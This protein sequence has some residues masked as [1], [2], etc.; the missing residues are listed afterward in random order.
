MTTTLSQ[1]DK[2][3]VE[4]AVDPQLKWLGFALIGLFA[5]F[6]LRAPYYIADTW[7]HEH[8]HFALFVPLGCAL[9]LWQ[10]PPR[11]QGVEPGPAWVSLTLFGLAAIFC[12][13]AFLVRTVTTWIAGFCLAMLALIHAWG[14]L[15]LVKQIWPAWVF[16]LLMV[17]PPQV[18]FSD[19]PV[20][21]QLL[22]S[23][24]SSVSLDRLLD[25]P[26]YLDGNIIRLDDRSLFVA[27]ACSGINSLFATF[28]VLAY[29]VLFYRR[30]AAHAVGLFMLGF[31]AVLG[32]NIFRVTS[33][34]AIY[35][36]APDWGSWLTYGMPHTIFGLVCFALLVGLVVSCDAFLSLFLRKRH[37]QPR[38][39]TEEENA[40]SKPSRS[41]PAW[42]TPAAAQPW[43]W[44]FVAVTFW[45]LTVMQVA[46]AATR[47]RKP[48]VAD[49]LPNQVQDLLP[50]QWRGY[51]MEDYEEFERGSEFI[52]ANYSSSWV[53]RN[54]E[55][56]MI[57]YL[58]RPY[59]D[60]HDLAAC[61]RAAGWSVQ[62]I[63]SAN[64]ALENSPQQDL[65]CTTFVVEKGDAPLQIF[66][67]AMIDYR[68][69]KTLAPGKR[70]PYSH[71]NARVEVLK[72]FGK[73]SE[74]P[75]EAMAI[76]VLFETSRSHINSDR[77]AAR[78][79]VRILAE[80]LI[81][82]LQGMH[83]N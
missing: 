49:P 12:F 75:R 24:F 14:G 35:W 50:V 22:V 29:A 79:S 67:Y 54:P 34:T 19:L 63:R 64:L 15:R 56:K 58:H 20:R 28:A 39:L 23:H 57:V 41:S 60:W 82:K 47:F 33:L 62:A 46:A 81:G 77:Q 6:A 61:Y 51:W 70:S 21:L 1:T 68:N 9:L 71:L 76:A 3:I 43:L 72:D 36:Y 4:A 45:G 74:A 44:G 66:A 7:A 83:S 11:L 17:R 18:I 30:T 55:R 52:Q 8:F 37:Q 40:Q 53:Y 42:F 16:L 78:E 80:Q 73:A 65:H 13:D 59:D 32:V 48:A 10:Y 27:E 2:P 5:A 69:G 38:S 26:H 31:L 25:I